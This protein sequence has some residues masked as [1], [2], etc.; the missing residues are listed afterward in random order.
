MGHSPIQEQLA[1]RGDALV[2]FSDKTDQDP[3]FAISTVPLTEVDLNREVVL[4]FE[5]GHWAR[6]VVIG[7]RQQTIRQKSQQ[8][9]SI[10]SD[11]GRLVIKA[12]HTLA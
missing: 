8:H 6:P 1:T 12:E 9:I 11:G 7:L 3:T 5:D 4:L 10:E 2:D